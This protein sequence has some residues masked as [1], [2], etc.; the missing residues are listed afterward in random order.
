MSDDLQSKQAYLRENVLEMGYDADEFMTFLQTKKGENGLDL[1]NW[2][3]NEL[4]TVVEEFVNNKKVKPN[5]QQ[6]Q[7]EVN[8]EKNEEENNKEIN[9]EYNNNNENNIDEKANNI[10]INNI[11]YNS[12]DDGDEYL[13]KCQANE[14]TSFSNVD[15]IRVKLSSPKKVEGK[16]FQKAFISYKINTEPFNFEM[17]KRYSDFLWLKKM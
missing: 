7:N 14:I 2:S 6:E 1:N 10:N 15:N 13:G 17:N 5:P 16:M 4:I 9:Q 3:M 12:I 8:E 11:Q